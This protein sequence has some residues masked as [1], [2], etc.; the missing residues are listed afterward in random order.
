[1]HFSPRKYYNFK[2]KIYLSLSIILTHTINKLIYIYKILV[3]LWNNFEKYTVFL[4]FFLY[5]LK[6]QSSSS[7]KIHCQEL[8][9]NYKAYNCLHTRLIKAFNDFN[10]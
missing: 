5:D 7:C 1:M 10:D 2:L 6:L 4:L 8:S 3:Q 9:Y